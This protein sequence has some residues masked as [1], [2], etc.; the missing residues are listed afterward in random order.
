MK[1]QNCNNET[2]QSRFLLV[3]M[4]LKYLL[5]FAILLLSIQSF[6]QKPADSI[7]EKMPTDLERDF[8]LSSMP[9]NVSRGATI[10]LLDPKKGYYISHQ[11]TNGFICFV[12]RTEL[13][14]VEFRTDIVTA[15]S[16]DAEGAKTIF[17]V[18][19]DVAAMRASGKFTAH[20]IKDS[21][22]ERYKNGYYKVPARGG[23]S[24]MVAPL[25]RNYE[26]LSPN[27]STFSVPHYMFYAPYI[28]EADIGGNSQSG[29]PM[30]FGN[31]K[32]PLGYL[33]I[34]VGKTEK[35]KILDENKVLLMR[36]AMYR[37]NLKMEGIGSHH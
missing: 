34:P 21:L 33:I 30:I 15:I 10:Y 20:Q 3:K 2:I 1:Q 5:I 22:T 35:A 24:Y 7:L 37:S 13:D 32:G 17:P 23:L 14:R 9:A 6:A 16:F 27:V 36:L 18:Y 29:G 26:G 4:N 12:I 11:G 8:A 28:T 25:M 31:G 19:A